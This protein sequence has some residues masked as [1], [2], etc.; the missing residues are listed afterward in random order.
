MGCGCSTKLKEG[1]DIVDHVISKGKE[2]FAPKVAHQI[3]C[4]CGE[5]FTLDTVIMNCPKCEMTY[6]VTP[7]GS[8][9]KNN[10]KLA[11]IKYA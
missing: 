1:K 11:G 8:D 7:C 4:G 6:A 10:I 2:K 3:E 5:I 9:N